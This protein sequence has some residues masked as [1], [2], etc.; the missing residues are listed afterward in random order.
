MAGNPKNVGL[1]SI[2]IYVYVMVLLSILS[3]VWLG[4]NYRLLSKYDT[5]IKKGQ[6]QLEQIYEWMPKIPPQNNEEETVETA[7]DTN[8]DIPF[9]FFKPSSYPEM[10]VTR[11]LDES[12]SREEY[13]E[14]RYLVT[15]NKGIRRDRLVRY[16]YD[17][18]KAKPFLR[19]TSLSLE[20]EESGEDA[21]K[22]QII[23]TQRIK[24]E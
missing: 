4:H 23:F 17:I 11:E 20:V 19:V 7:T 12:S 5:S 1:N 15:V 14:K 6:K 8:Q 22:G 21:W 9:A 24:K 10:E 16:I 13:I 18:L 3:L 2:K